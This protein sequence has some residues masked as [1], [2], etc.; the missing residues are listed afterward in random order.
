MFRSLFNNMP[1]VVKNLVII[2]ALFFLAKFVL[3]N[4]GIDAGKLLGVHY[5]S[6]Q[7]FAP[8]QLVTHFFMHGDIMHIFFNMFA[9]IV[10]GAHLERRWGPQKFLLFYFITALGA[11]FLHLLVQGFEI[12]QIAGE[13]FPDVEILDI[14]NLGNGYIRLDVMPG[15]LSEVGGMYYTT[16]VGA[17]GAVYGLIAAFAMLFPDVKLMLMFPPIPIKAK[18]LAIGLGVFALYQG[19]KDA[20]GD[21][22]AH[23]AHLGGMIFGIIL[24]KIWQRSENRFY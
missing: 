2:N 22:I 14:I 21:S 5:P 11:A 3:E 24:V 10:F 18:W 15:H 1:N 8:Y 12:Y 6:S 16:T 13:F 9:L 17:S 20:A 23:F 19:Y 7:Y 4:Q